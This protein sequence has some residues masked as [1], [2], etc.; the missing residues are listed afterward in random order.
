M[1]EPDAGTAPK[2]RGKSKETMSEPES[3]STKEK[4]LDLEPVRAAVFAQLLLRNQV[5]NHEPR[6]VDFCLRLANEA[7]EKYKMAR[8][9][10]GQ[11]P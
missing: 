10:I 6:E 4:E 7:A 5:A 2:P 9:R 11:K 3:L 1:T 8:T